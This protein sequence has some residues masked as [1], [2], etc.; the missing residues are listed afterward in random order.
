MGVAFRSL[1]L[2]DDPAYAASFGRLIR[3]DGHEHDRAETLAAARR[4][5]EAHVY[6]MLILDRRLADGDSLDLVRDLRGRG[7]RT[8]VA[9]LTAYYTLGDEALALEA[10]ADEYMSKGLPTSVILARLGVLERRAREFVLPVGPL[11]L[12]LD[13]GLLCWPSGERCTLTVHEGRF[14]RA[15]AERAGR[16]VSRREL[17]DA[18]W[19]GETRGLSGLTTLLNRLRDKLGDE[20]C[21]LIETHN[22]HG[23]RLT[24]GPA[25]RTAR[26]RLRRR[27]THPVSA[28]CRAAS[29]DAKHR[30]S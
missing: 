8:H 10:G 28:R 6:D 17:A 29:V 11:V 26:P 7:D 23:Y 1:L 18:V 22:R 12:R 24:T 4:A 25:V 16:T 2:D 15:L 5:V 14:L 20:L 21:W 13:R 9:M 3:K 27:G 30:C 19:L